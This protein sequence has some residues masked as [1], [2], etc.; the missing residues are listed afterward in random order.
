MARMPR[1]NLYGHHQPDGYRPRS[2]R[3][4]RV[5]WT[6]KWGLFLGL[7]L[8]CIL[9]FLCFRIIRKVAPDLDFS[10]I[11]NG[12]S[13]DMSSRINRLGLL[14]TALIMLIAFLKIFLNST[15]NKSK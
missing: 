13:L 15:R 10:N 7:P 2:H 5:R 11:L 1:H 4:R 9:C 14:G 3:R 12:F 6:F 8:M